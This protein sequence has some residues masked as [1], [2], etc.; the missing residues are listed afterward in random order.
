MR[1]P[2][3]DCEAG[4]APFACSCRVL[5]AT[6]PVA[7]R[8]PFAQYSSRPV[9]YDSAQLAGWQAVYGW[10]NDVHAAAA[11]GAAAGAVGIPHGR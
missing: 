10:L 7:A 6:T 1:L 11:A 2:M 5:S 8:L 4:R 3:S 9:R